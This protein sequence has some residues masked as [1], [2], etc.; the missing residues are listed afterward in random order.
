M[1]RKFSHL[2]HLYFAQE[3]ENQDTAKQ[4]REHFLISS[5]AATGGV[6]GG[7]G[8]S[9]NKND[10][11][12]NES[13]ESSDSGSSF[14]GSRGNNESSLQP[15]RNGRYIRVPTNEDQGEKSR[16]EGRDVTKRDFSR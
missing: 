1:H 2:Y 10:A 12:V 7:A 6:G 8:A 16:E 11:A 5:R 15:H 3:R 13:T 14:G 4:K 9:A